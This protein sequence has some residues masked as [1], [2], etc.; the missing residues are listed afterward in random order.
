VKEVVLTFWTEG[1]A[2]SISK[3]VNT[4]EDASTTVVTE[5]DLLVCTAGQSRLD[6]CGSAT[7]GTRRRVHSYFNNELELWEEE[8]RTS[9][10][11]VKTSNKNV[12]RKI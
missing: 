10:E 12:L 3:D 2:D 4:L 5:L 9:K 7:E 11:S 1:D 6:P 8:E